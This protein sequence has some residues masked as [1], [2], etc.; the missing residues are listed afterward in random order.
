MYEQ[1]ASYLVKHLELGA[2]NL[3]KICLKIIQ[4]ILKWPLQYVNFKKYSGEA[5]PRTP[6]AFFILKMLQNN[7][8]GKNY[9]G[10]YFKF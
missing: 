6:R 7:S 3:N 1:N 5:C 4:K 2:K 8:A 10:K 9:T